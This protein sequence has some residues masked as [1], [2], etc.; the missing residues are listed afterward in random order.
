MFNGKYKVDDSFVHLIFLPRKDNNIEMFNR[1][2]RLISNLFQD[3]EFSFLWHKNGRLGKKYIQ[4]NCEG[5]AVQHQHIVGLPK[6][7]IKN[8]TKQLGMY[9]LGSAIITA[10]DKI[11]TEQHPSFKIYEKGGV[12]TESK[13]EKVDKPFQTLLDGENLMTAKPAYCIG[14][15]NKEQ[16]FEKNIVINKEV[17]GESGFLRYVLTELFNDSSVHSYEKSYKRILSIINSDRKTKMI[18]KKQLLALKYKLVKELSDVN[19][20]I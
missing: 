8:L 6:T 20:L 1:L 17:K 2:L 12:F 13:V 19:Y 18:I 15:K 7:D 3:R 4:C 9:D 10:F 5:G 11:K 16:Y 14:L